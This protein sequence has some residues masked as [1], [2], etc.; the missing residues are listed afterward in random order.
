MNTIRLSKE[1]GRAGRKGQKSYAICVFDPEDAACH[2]FARNIPAYLNQSHHV[3]INK[4]NS[5]SF[6]KNMTASIGMEK[7]A[8]IESN[9]SKFFEFANS[10]NLR[11]ASGEITIFYNSKKIGT[12]DIPVGYYQ[13]HQNGIYHFNKQNYQVESI[14]KTA[15]W[16]RCI[17]KKI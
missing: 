6:Q 12:R 11:G 4:D 8:A 17:F 3:E 16:R 15:K 14:I 10:I 1:S 9:K 13:L 2:Y 7:H 5:L